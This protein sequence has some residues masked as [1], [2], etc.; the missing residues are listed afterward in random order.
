MRH[1]R[2][3]ELTLL[4]A[5]AGVFAIGY[6]QLGNDVALPFLGFLT[7]F[8]AMHLGVRAWAPRSDPLLLPLTALLFA[9]GSMQLASIDHLQSE[10]SSGWKA[11]AP[12]QTGWLAF[13]TAAFLVILY[14]FRNGL[15]PAWRTRYTLALLGIVS[16]LAPLL[17]GIGY[18]VRGARLWLRFGPLSFQPGE[19]AKVLIV[20]FLAAYLSETTGTP[21]SWPLAGSVR[22]CYPS[23]AT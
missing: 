20:L 7:S 14:L 4:I 16:L 1:P 13:S 23:R 10:V 15:G 3:R 18:Q 11:L 21:R 8:G 2:L 12:L 22:C 17:P 6:I 19:A 9:I 5:T